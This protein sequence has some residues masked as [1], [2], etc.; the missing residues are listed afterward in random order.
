MDNL[1]H[2][3]LA[4][5]LSRAGLSRRTPYATGLLVM[6]ANAPDI[7]V[8]SRFGSLI[9]YLEHHRGITHSLITSPVLAAA[10]VGLFVMGRKLRQKAS[11]EPPPF[12][13][14]PAWLIAWFG[15]LSHL[16]LDYSTQYGTRLL[17]PFS[18]RWLGWGTVPVVDIWVLALLAA[19]LGFPS[20]FR[21]VSEEIGAEP[22][23]AGSARPWAIFALAAMTAW[24]GFRDLSHRRAVA[25]VDSHL[26]HDREPRRSSAYPDVLNPFLWHGVADTGATM[27]AVEVNLLDEFDPTRA[28]T[29]WPPE[30]NPA[31]EAARKTRTARVFW[32]FA[33]Y[34]F[35]YVDRTEQGYE[36]VFRDLRFDYGVAGRRGFVARVLLDEQLRVLRESFH[37]QDPQPAR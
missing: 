18:G 15:V 6:A 9:N 10:V 33:A 23:A 1:T 29:Y 28:R 4:V 12:P 3:L 2:S 27:E 20:L 25:L 34:P 22:A 13:F 36:I 19:G 30:P 35:V 7:D 31:L 11:P 5:T 32:D 24:W 8:V 17:L 14:L 16:L 21:L 37:F 26:Y